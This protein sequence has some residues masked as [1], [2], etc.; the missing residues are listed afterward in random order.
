MNSNLL[1]VDDNPA[2]LAALSELLEPLSEKV[3]C[4]K[5]PELI[6][7]IENIFLLVIIDQFAGI[8]KQGFESS[9]FIIPYPILID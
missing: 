6:P 5:S 8:Y 2:V 1:V 4:I 7:G 9:D 3:L